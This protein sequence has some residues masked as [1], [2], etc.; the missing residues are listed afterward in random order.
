MAPMYPPDG[1]AADLQSWA[2]GTLYRVLKYHLGPDFSFAHGTKWHA[3]DDDDR[4][5]DGKADLAVIYPQHGVL[6]LE[7]GGGGVHVLAAAPRWYMINAAGR[8][9]QSPTVLPSD[10]VDACALA[11]VATRASR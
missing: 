2:E 3:R 11:H 9:S 1:P 6:V 8:R 4:A 7:V 5:Q 10:E